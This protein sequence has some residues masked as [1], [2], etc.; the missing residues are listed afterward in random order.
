MPFNA[1]NALKVT[2]TN[3]IHKWKAILWCEAKAAT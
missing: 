1:F 2:A 3:I